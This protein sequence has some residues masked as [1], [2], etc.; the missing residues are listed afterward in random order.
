MS[1]IRVFLVQEKYKVKKPD[2]KTWPVALF[3]LKLDAE[4][5]IKDHL[6]PSKFMTYDIVEMDCNMG[7]DYSKDIHKDKPQMMICRTM[8]QFGNPITSHA[9]PHVKNNDC[10]KK[11]KCI[12]VDDI[13]SKCPVCNDTGYVGAKVA[14]CD[15]KGIDEVDELDN[16][17]D[18]LTACELRSHAKAIN[19]LIRTIGSGNTL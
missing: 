17:D 11:P 19:K 7:V 1:T 15:C 6:L 9:S 18:S 5:F 3:L 14:K 4:K 13:P 16:D 2:P 12:P 10:D 8:K